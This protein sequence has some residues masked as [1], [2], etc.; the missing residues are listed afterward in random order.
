M[1]MRIV[2]SCFKKDEDGFFNSKSELVYSRSMVT[3]LSFEDVEQ[4]VRPSDG[5]YITKT[6]GNNISYLDC[7][8]F[9]GQENEIIRRI[10]QIPEKE[11]SARTYSKISSN[12]IL[13]VTDSTE[14]DWAEIRSKETPIVSSSNEYWRG[15]GAG[16]HE[17]FAIAFSV[18]LFLLS[19]FYGRS[20]EHLLSSRVMKGRS[21]IK[22]RAFVVAKPKKLLRNVSLWINHD[23]E[24]LQ[25]INCHKL[26]D[27]KFEAII[28]TFTDKKYRVTCSSKSK[29]I[30][31]SEMEMFQ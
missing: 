10:A 1:S 19:P 27:D 17:L 4:I 23:V 29:I 5:Y 30:E 25:I 13:V 22:G 2:V 26:D 7:S 24:N 6:K 16:D 12:V 21:W 8:Y 18:L 31:L 11:F 20:I 14:E 28:G 3:D 15:A 9:H